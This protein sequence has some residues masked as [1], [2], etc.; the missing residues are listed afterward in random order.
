MRFSV[1]VNEEDLFP[2]IRLRDKTN[3]TEAEIYSFGA[4]LN[5]FTVEGK[6]RRINVID[7]FISPANARETITK[8]FKSSKL[9]PFVCRLKKGEYIFNGEMYKIEKFY[10]DSE[11]IHG[12]LFDA[13]FTVE[14]YGTGDSSA[15][16][17]LLYKYS[18]K[19]EGY[20]FAY[21]VDVV[22]TLKANN[23]LSIQTLV[24]NN[25]EEDM[26]LNDGWHPYFQLGETVN[27]LHVQFNSNAMV[28]FNSDLLPTG[29]FTPYSKFERMELFG[30]TRLDN[31]FV[32][33]NSLQPACILRDEKAGIQLSIKTDESYPY[34]QVFTPG[35]RKSI[36]IENLS[37]APDSFNNGIGLIIVKPG[38][39]YSFATSYQITLL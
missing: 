1:Q 38:E 39:Q 8:T 9:S 34:L 2:V 21:A 11:A 30:E 29:K 23:T 26:P 33:K 35:H 16:V 10:L 14:D 5:S 6:K 19:E 25:S 20:P 28:E 13:T 37:S 22:Y 36:A 27:N 31:C 12:L 4:I 3:D 15:F 17:R 24:I 18:K 32:L 7:G